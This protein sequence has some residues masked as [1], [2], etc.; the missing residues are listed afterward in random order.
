MLS[1]FTVENMELRINVSPENSATKLQH[2][3]IAVSCMLHRYVFTCR[4]L[5]E[6]DTLIALFLKREPIRIKSILQALKTKF[7]RQSLTTV[8]QIRRHSYYLYEM[9]FLLQ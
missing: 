2:A 7:Y 3:L 4:Y 5:L 8:K 9:R 6:V 1:S